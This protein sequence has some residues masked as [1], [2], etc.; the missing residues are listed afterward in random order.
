[1]LKQPKVLLALLSQYIEITLYDQY[2]MEIAKIY[3]IYIYI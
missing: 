1:M 3:M 2:K